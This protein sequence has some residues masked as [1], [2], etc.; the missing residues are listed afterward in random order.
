MQTPA[1]RLAGTALAAL[2]VLGAAACGTSGSATD[3]PAPIPTGTTPTPAAL[4]YDPTAVISKSVLGPGRV[5]AALPTA[6]GGTR[7]LVN[8]RLPGTELGCEGMPVEGLLA[9]DDDGNAAPVLAADGGSIVNG[10]TIATPPGALHE[11]SLV[12]LSS[13]CEGFTSQV[14]VGTI[15]A[16][17]IPTGIV[18]IAGFE[19]SQPDRVAGA[20]EFDTLV[21]MTWTP[22]SSRLLLVTSAYNFDAP[23][24]PDNHLWEYDPV[25]ATWTERTDAPEGIQRALVTASGVLVTMAG[26]S[27]LYGGHEFAR[28]GASHFVLA[29]D[30]ET[31]AVV[32]PQQLR[33]ITPDGAITPIADGDIGVAE[34]LPDGSGLIYTRTL[35]DASGVRFAYLSLD[36]QATAD[37][38]TRY[39]GWFAVAPDGSGLYVTAGDLGS[40][41]Y[42]DSEAE[43]WS[44]APLA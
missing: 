33:I 10:V 5:L 21:D 34:F 43:F 20:P 36:G 7:I 23:E 29:P 37:L 27:M 35:P 6:D 9:L 44:F 17:G 15:G 12:A 16:D 24:R 30:A 41:G 13:M 3:T 18:A 8:D 39:W 4:A 40:D 2:L 32:G 14:L 1:H 22:D 11:G 25:S 28:E 31:I 38:G 42:T 26:E 19:G